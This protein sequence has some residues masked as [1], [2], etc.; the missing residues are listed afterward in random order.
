MRTQLHWLLLVGLACLFH[1]SARAQDFD[2]LRPER[3]QELWTAASVRGLAPWVFKDLLGDNY[4]KLVVSGELG[5]RS[6]DNFF[7][8][9]QVYV[10]LGG[11]YKVNKWLRLGT[12]YRY[13]M[14]NGP[15]N[16]QR[17]GFIA[18]LDKKF[19]RMELGYRFVFQRNYLGANKARNL[20][21]NR[22]SVDYDIPKWKLDPELSLEFFTLSNNQGL[23]YIG[24]RYR[25]GTS[26]SPWKGH[27][28]SP[29]IVYDRDRNVAFPVYRTIF[30]I[31]YKIDLRKL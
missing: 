23:T 19:G 8:G 22:I 29:A 20:F 18:D 5:Y 11:K 12:E 21:R 17:I 25:F 7:A 16:R 9:R 3:T 2:D 13:A 27:T 30:S 1:R 10:D 4:R 28:F 15:N 26:F 24:T 14:R 31:D 6:A